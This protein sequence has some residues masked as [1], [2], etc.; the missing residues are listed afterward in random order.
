MEDTIKREHLVF[1]DDAARTLVQELIIPTLKGLRETYHEAKS[2]IVAIAVDSDD[3]FYELITF[4]NVDPEV[5]ADNPLNTSMRI[6][7]FGKAI[8]PI[9]SKIPEIM[10]AESQDSSISAEYFPSDGETT[11]LCICTMQSTWP[12]VSKSPQAYFVCLGFLL[13][14][15]SFSL[16]WWLFIH[17]GC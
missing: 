15:Y 4:A 2:C 8:L 3:D 17:C 13:S 10:K 11:N 14:K 9:L 1:V 5:G 6:N 7:P 12:T 16:N